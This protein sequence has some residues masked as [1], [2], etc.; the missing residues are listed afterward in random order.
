MILAVGRAT[1]MFVSFES[2]PL[3]EPVCSLRYAP[4]ARASGHPPAPP[5]GPPNGRISLRFFPQYESLGT[6]AIVFQPQLHNPRALW[7]AYSLSL[8]QFSLPCLS[9]GFPA[10]LISLFQLPTLSVVG[11]PVVEP[12][13]IRQVGPSWALVGYRMMTSFQYSVLVAVS[14]QDKYWRF[15][16]L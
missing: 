13:L 6:I 15:K 7:T 11:C 8:N 12:V 16:L 10:L 3:A 14:S 9:G 5:L 2:S 4:A 1:P